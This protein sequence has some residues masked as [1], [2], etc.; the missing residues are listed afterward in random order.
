MQARG[1]WNEILT[2]ERRKPKL[3]NK[4]SRGFIKFMGGEGVLFLTIFYI[5]NKLCLPKLYNFNKF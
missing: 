3:E 1:E 4:I 5:Y 2:I